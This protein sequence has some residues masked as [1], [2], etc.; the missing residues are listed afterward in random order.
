MAVSAEYEVDLRE[1]REEAE[2]RPFRRMKP[3]MPDEHDQVRPG[4]KHLRHDPF[5]RFAVRFEIPAG[6]GQ[7]PFRHLGI[8]HADDC[9]FPSVPFE[10]R[11][12]RGAEAIAAVL[13]AER[14]AVEPFCRLN[15]CV[16]PEFKIVVA[17]NPD[18]EPEQVHEVDHRPS[19]VE[20]REER[21][22]QG[23]AA[24]DPDRLRVRP[25]ERRERGELLRPAV[26]VGRAE[27]L[28]LSGGKQGGE[29]RRR[30]KHP[31]PLHSSTV[32]KIRSPVSPRP[33]MM[34]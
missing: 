30:Q 21:S 32:P 1:F 24:I 10:E 16:G 2:H 14:L 25:Q 5:Q 28:H 9:D 27:N 23:V 33:G 12:R 20:A 19:V 15:Q 29:E 22:L 17:G 18:V 8:G 6:V 11:P 3:R 31:C 4:G 13:R 7:Q 34:Y 26:H